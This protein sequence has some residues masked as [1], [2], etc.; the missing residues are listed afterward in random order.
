M[1][2]GNGAEPGAA[3]GPASDLVAVDVH[4]DL[5]CAWAYPASLWLCA[6]RDRPTIENEVL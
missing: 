5:V 2:R 4:T 1:T 6:A 3:R